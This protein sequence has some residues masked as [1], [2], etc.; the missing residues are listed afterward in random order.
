MGVCIFSAH[1]NATPDACHVVGDPA[2][3]NGD[4]LSVGHEDARTKLGMVGILLRTADDAAGHR[5]ATVILVYRAAVIRRF[6]ANKAAAAEC[7]R[8]GVDVKAAALI[9]RTP[10]DRRVGALH[11]QVAAALVDAA[12]QVGGVRLARRSGAVFIKGH[13]RGMAFGDQR[14]LA[15]RGD[16]QRTIGADA[17]AYPGMAARNDAIQIQRTIVIYA[18]AGGHR[19]AVG[20]LGIVQ[21][22]GICI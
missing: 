13:R 19:V 5:K 11:L 20:N 2:T 10:A 1:G 3:A 4:A 16:V 7:R 17:A 21:G 15:R 18:A 8:T 14:G 12:A 9:S 22:K 6:V